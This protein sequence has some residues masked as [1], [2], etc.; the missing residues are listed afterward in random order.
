MLPPPE[1]V[2]RRLHFVNGVPPE[3]HW[4]T[5]NPVARERGGMGTQRMTVGTWLD[6]IEQEKASGTGHI[7]PCGGNL[8]RP[9]ERGGC[10]C[11]VCTHNRAVLEAREGG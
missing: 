5:R 3:Y 9:E 11:E 4:T 1:M 7:G 6:V 2:F 8:P 10:E